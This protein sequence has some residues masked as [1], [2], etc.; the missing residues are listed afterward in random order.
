MRHFIKRT[1]V[2]DSSKLIALF[3]FR[4]YPNTKKN[5][6]YHT[7]ILY[8][9]AQNP[10]F[11]IFSYRKV[12]TLKSPFCKKKFCSNQIWWYQLFQFSWFFYIAYFNTLIIPASQ[13]LV[14]KDTIII[15]WCEI[16]VLVTVN[17]FT[18]LKTKLLCPP[19]RV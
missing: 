7:D 5:I 19:E 16:L 17:R 18:I 8:K 4:F 9:S 3:I 2:T 15:W 14:A 12:I 1:T 10:I 11:P 13:F 6:A